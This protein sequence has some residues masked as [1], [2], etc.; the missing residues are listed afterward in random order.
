MPLVI[1]VS[2][3]VGQL[4]NGEEAAFAEKVLAAVAEEGGVVPPLFWYEVRNVLVMCERKAGMTADQSRLFLE[5]LDDL[6]LEIDPLPENE[7][8]L[9]AARRHALTIY[10]AA[11]LKLAMRRGLVLAT[12][13]RALARAAHAHGVKLM[14]PASFPEI[15]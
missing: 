10:D 11:Y 12:T 14:A 7:Q 8:V 1:D 15:E 5:S 9:D 2:A 6:A 13:D 4:L 3:I